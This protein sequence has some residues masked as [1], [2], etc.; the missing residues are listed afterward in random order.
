MSKFIPVFTVGDSVEHCEMG[1]GKV[2]KGIVIKVSV[3]GGSE[4]V[5]IAGVTDFSNAFSMA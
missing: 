3:K 5:T 2:T 1:T 4:V